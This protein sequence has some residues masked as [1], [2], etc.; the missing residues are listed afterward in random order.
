VPP[1][2]RDLGLSVAL[3]A[4]GVVGTSAAAVEQAEARDL[5]WVAFVLLLAGPALLLLRRRHQVAVL[6]GILAVTIVY[7]LLD[8]PHGPVFLSLV[9]AFVTT[10][11]TGHRRAAWV[12]LSIG[13]VAFLWLPMA[14]GHAAPTLGALVGLTAWLLVLA[15][16]SEIVRGRREQAVA[17][18]RS[19]EEERRR[20]ASDERLRMAQELHDVLAH[21]LSLISVQ[22]GVAL[23]LLE[24][25]P[26]ST[27]PALEAIREASGDAL[28]E[29]RRV[30]DVLRADGAA[31]KA[32]APSLA[33][34]DQLV[35][36]T[37]AAGIEASLSVSGVARPVPGEVERAAY[38]IV[39][40]SLTNATRYAGG[41]PVRVAVGFGD[42]AVTVQVDDDGPGPAPG[43]SPGSGN[44]IAGMRERAAALGGSLDAGPRA[45]GGFRVRAWLP[46]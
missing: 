43:R 36:R 41:A 32:P 39:Q 35:A 42:D 23:H 11:L 2:L 33:D 22:A 20:R 16:T 30:L 19:A 4:V 40:E 18:A 3:A 14:A 25:K 21:D 13:W 38:R 28:G 17:A 27:R 7:N 31:P 1:R 24:D 10:V 26:E 12:A 15:T 6:F 5:D 46:T 29:L 9:V 34:L 37:V 44:G 45:G 8:F